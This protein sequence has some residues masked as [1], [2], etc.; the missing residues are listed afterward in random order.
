MY[1]PFDISLQ[2]VEKQALILTLCNNNHDLTL[3]AYFQK[4][5]GSYEVGLVVTKEQ[6]PGQQRWG[7]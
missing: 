6:D 2:G 3:R 5:P 4:P 1:W 7:V